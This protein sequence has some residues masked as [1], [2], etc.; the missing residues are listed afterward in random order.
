MGTKNILEEIYNLFQEKMPY[1]VDDKEICRAKKKL[2]ALI[3]DMDN[4]N[5][6]LD[7]GIAT[8]KAGFRYGFML[9]VHIMAQCINET[10][11]FIF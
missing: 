6:I 9:A 4:E 10:S 11:K 5:V 1:S 3:G 2:D 8:E 7:Y